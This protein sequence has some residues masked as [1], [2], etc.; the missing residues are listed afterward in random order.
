MNT[1]STLPPA[2]TTVD[3][4]VPAGWG[5]TNLYVPSPFSR[6]K[7]AAHAVVPEPQELR[8]MSAAPG[9]LSEA[10]PTVIPM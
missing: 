3:S 9:P 4:M 5:K 8:H 10:V 6:P 2:I 1:M 7:A